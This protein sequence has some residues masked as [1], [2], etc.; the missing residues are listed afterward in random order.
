VD[1]RVDTNV[2]EENTFSIFRAKELTVARKGPN[3]LIH[4]I[5]RRIKHI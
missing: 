4:E 1:L 2:S 3:D 5:F